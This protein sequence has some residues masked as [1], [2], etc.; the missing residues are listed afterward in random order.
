MMAPDI[1][2]SQE[3]KD[4]IRLLR[5]A[6]FHIYHERQVQDYWHRTEVSPTHML[7]FKY[8][9]GGD[10]N[11]FV[12]ELKLTSGKRIGARL[13]QEG[14]AEWGEEETGMGGKI[15]WLRLRVV[16]PFAATDKDIFAACWHS[17]PR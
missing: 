15:Y 9:R 16:K 1:K 6:G 7:R 12:S 3:E 13:A 14:I 2:L 17:Q 5:A 11:S 4:A 8:E 10:R